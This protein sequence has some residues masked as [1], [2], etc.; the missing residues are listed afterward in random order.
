MTTLRDSL[1]AGGDSD[2]VQ[3]GVGVSIIDNEFRGIYDKGENHTDAIQLIGA[4]GAIVRGNFVHDSATGIVAYDGLR[5]AIIEDNV[6]ALENRASGIEVYSDESSIIRHNTL[7]DGTCTALARAEGVR[8]GLIELNRKPGTP[9]GWDT[10]VVDNIATEIT[11]NN[12]STMQPSHHNLLSALA[13]P[14][15]TLGS[16]LY[17]GGE[18]PKVYEDFALAASSPGKAAASDGTDVGARPRPHAIPS[19]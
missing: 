10:L 7:F 6:I 1:F 2:G 16:P 14:L 19:R 15:D 17:V 9:P 5:S 4:T 13:G 3:S 11:T 12:G 8:C 18:H